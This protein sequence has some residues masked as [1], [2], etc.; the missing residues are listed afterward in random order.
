[1]SESRETI[2][3]SHKIADR[4]AAFSVL[5]TNQQQMQHENEPDRQG[6]GEGAHGHAC[7]LDGLD[8]MQSGKETP[9]PSLSY[10]DSRMRRRRPEM[11]HERKVRDRGN[12]PLLCKRPGE[13]TEV[14]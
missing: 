7:S 5:E 9:S 1:V 13:L 11:D 2:G 12:Y 8:P 3:L 10:V 4:F 6:D 14:P